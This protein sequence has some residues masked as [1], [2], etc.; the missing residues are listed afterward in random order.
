MD[1]DCEPEVAPESHKS[2]SIMQADLEELEVEQ[3]YDK[4]VLYCDKIMIIRHL[5]SS[6]EIE[7]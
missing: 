2:N 5:Q 1:S 3:S 4:K 6:C 7:S